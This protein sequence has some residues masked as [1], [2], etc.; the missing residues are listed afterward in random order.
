MKLHTVSMHIGAT[1][2]LLLLVLALSAGLAWMWF[3]SNGQM[4][5]MTWFKPQ[6][7]KPDIKMPSLLNLG[8]TQPSIASAV[9]LERPMFAPDRRP[10]P[11]PPPPVAPPPPDPL[12]NLQIKGIFD[13]ETAGIL[14][15]LDGKSRR[16]K[17]NETIGPWTLKSIDGRDITFTQ[18]AESR[19]IHMA[20]TRLDTPAP[21][22][23]ATNVPPAPGSAPAP[24]AIALPQNQQD[25][26]RERLQRRNELRASRGLPPVT[27]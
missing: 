9:I 10:P 26:M 27:D 3:D 24:N 1:R 15:L 23:F 25:Q 11:P 2:I 18:G 4:R 14:A 21:K 17:L 6:A 12:A 8:Q 16:I 20:Y 7:V 5:H 13:G 22:P 19:K